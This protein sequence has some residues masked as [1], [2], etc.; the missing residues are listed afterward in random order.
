VLIAVGFG[1]ENLKF[2]GEPF[3][4]QNR[5]VQIVNTEIKATATLRQ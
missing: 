2:P 3:A 4:D 1:K 5:R